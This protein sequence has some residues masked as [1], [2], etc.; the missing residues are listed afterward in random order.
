MEQNTIQIPDKENQEKDASGNDHIPEKSVNETSKSELFVFWLS[1]RINKQGELK[2][3][4]NHLN[5]IYFLRYRGFRRFDINDDFIFVKIKDHILEEIPIHRIQD[6]VIDYINS[7]K[8]SDLEGITKEEL[9]SK[10][11]TSPAI[12][13]NEK[14]LSILGI[15]KGLI[16]NSDSKEIGYIYYKNGF[17][18]CSSDG[19][20][21]HDYKELE[22]Y[23]FKNQ[24]KNREFKE[25]TSD[26]MFSKFIWNI[27]GK[28]E[29]R[30]QSLQTLIGYLLHSFYETKMKAVNL[31]DSTISDNAEGRSGKTLLGRAI[32]HIKMVC[33]ISGKDFDP[34]NKH[35]YSSVN[36]DTQIVFLNDLR[37]RFD[38]ESLFNDISDAITV[39]R[40]NLQPFTIRAKMLISSNDTFKIEG[41]S[42]KDRVIEFELADHYNAEHSPETEFGC[43]F[44]RDWN[45]EEWQMFDNFMCNCLS[46]FLKNGLIEADQINLDRRKL[47]N[48]TNPDFVAFMNEKVEKGEFQLNK[49]YDKTQ[50]HEEFLDNYSEYRF[51]NW[52]KRTGNFT[53]YLK[54]FAK[55]SDALKAESK[56]RRSNG[57]SLIQFYNNTVSQIADEKKIDEL[58]F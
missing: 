54:T 2:W 42:A 56:E 30:F 9:L 15:E 27:S 7:I 13:F 17:I 44:F 10:F 28:N 33:E 45:C 25:S 29:K 53:K 57:R 50:L 52:L 38:F 58:P 12:F 47:L 37:K 16:F 20:K 31:T 24:I 51:D 41:A 8:E 34:T 32:A 1:E 40:K 6:E 49:D 18:R 4:I 23:I 3:K 55:Y 36:L 43:W 5:F 26:G 19:Y 35:K 11:V 39:D 22:G 46:S 14:K 21:L 48:E